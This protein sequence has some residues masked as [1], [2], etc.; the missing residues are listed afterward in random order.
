M[1]ELL[2]WRPLPEVGSLWRERGNVYSLRTVRVLA[3]EEH[4]FI[5]VETVTRVDGNP[6]KRPIRSRIRRTQ[7]HYAYEPAD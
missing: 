6:P 5:H 1:T 2:K 4:G 7:W 3:A